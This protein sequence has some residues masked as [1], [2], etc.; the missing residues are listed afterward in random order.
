MPLYDPFQLEASAKEAVAQLHVAVQLSP[1]VTPAL[2]IAFRIG[3]AILEP[4]H[5]SSA[6]IRTEA[7]HLGL[8]LGIV[9]VQN[10][11]N[12]SHNYRAFG[13]IL[14]ST[15]DS[16]EIKVTIQSAVKSNK[17]G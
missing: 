9:P 3:R 6:L 8:D 5:I 11:R 12:K 1:L 14:H 2:T 15:S 13:P 4:S 7:F 10:S 17:Q 16:F